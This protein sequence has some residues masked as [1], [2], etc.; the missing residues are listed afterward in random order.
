[1]SA[2]RFARLVV[3]RKLLC[4]MRLTGRRAG[5]VLVYHA[6][7]DEQG[8]PSRELVP[9][10]SAARFEGHLRHLAARYRVVPAGELQRA[11]GGRRRGGR[12]PVAITFDDDL[13]TH[14]TIA[15]PLLQRHR[16][17]AT[18]FLTGATLERPAGFWWQRLQRAASA[19]FPLPL[20]GG[21]VHAVAGQIERLTATEQ[22]RIAAD[23]ATLVGVE[24]DELGLR[25][26]GVRRLAEAGFGI[27]SHTRRHFRLRGLDDPELARALNEGRAELEAIA[28]RPLAAISYPH[29]QADERVAAAARAAGFRQG[30]TGRYAPVTAES[31]PMLLARIEPAFGP[32]GS[33]AAQLVGVLLRRPHR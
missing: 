33:F 16:V 17:P 13:A 18:F 23:L 3:A 22:E 21:D 28:G 32:S 2:L 25:A 6:L 30:F 29:G 31:D 27:G 26:E 11:A 4:L 20:G 9:A 10:H 8:D 12:F 24:G 19:G 7:A 1:M 5:L 14:V 15:L